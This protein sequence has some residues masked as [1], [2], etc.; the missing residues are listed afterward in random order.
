[1]LT[2]SS[3]I[4]PSSDAV[5]IHSPKSFQRIFG[6]ERPFLSIQPTNPQFYTSCT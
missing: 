2:L 4:H 6:Y 3:L 5:I 1:L